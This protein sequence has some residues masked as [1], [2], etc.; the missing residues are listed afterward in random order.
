MPTGTRQATQAIETAAS[1]ACKVV[2]PHGGLK[3]GRTAGAAGGAA[4]ERAP[5]DR[6]HASP[7]ALELSGR[8]LN[9]GMH[10]VP[11]VCQFVEVR[12]RGSLRGGED[13]GGRGGL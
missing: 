7:K 12:G 9:R 3:G 11:G 1:G 10:R 4:S 5:K 8:C 6:C 13:S 2:E